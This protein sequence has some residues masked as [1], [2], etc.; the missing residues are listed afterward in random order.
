MAQSSVDGEMQYPVPAARSNTPDSGQN[1]EHEPKPEPAVPVLAEPRPVT[2]SMTP[3]N[4]V[5]ESSL[6]QGRLSAQSPRPIHGHSG[7]MGTPSNKMLYMYHNGSGQRSD[8][9][10]EPGLPSFVNSE[11]IGLGAHYPQSSAGR[12]SLLVSP[13][14][15]QDIRAD[16]PDFFYSQRLNRG[17]TMQAS[18]Q[19]P[20][21]TGEVYG[22]SG[23]SNSPGYFGYSNATYQQVIGGQNVPQVLYFVD[24]N[25]AAASSGHQHI[26]QRQL[27]SPSNNITTALGNSIIQRNTGSPQPQL[28]YMLQEANS[29]VIP[30]QRTPSSGDQFYV[31]MRPPSPSMFAQHSASPILVPRQNTPVNGGDPLLSLAPAAAQ[32]L[33]A[34]LANARARL[35]GAEDVK[36]S[37]NPREQAMTLNKAEVE[38]FL[39][40][41]KTGISS[42]TDRKS[43]SVRKSLG[44]S[45]G[46]PDSRE[47]LF[48]CHWEGC[49][50]GYKRREH[51]NRHIR[52]HTGE[53]PYV[54][55]VSDC[56]K[57]F[58]RSDNL[59]NHY[60]VHQL[61]NEV[62]PEL[63]VKQL[64]QLVAIM[65]SHTHQKLALAAQHHHPYASAGM[66]NAA[67]AV[68]A[69]QLAPLTS[70]NRQ[71]SSS[72]Q[73]AGLSIYSN[74]Y[75]ANQAGSMRYH[76]FDNNSK[77]QQALPLP[78][79]YFAN[80]YL[81]N[82]PPAFRGG[83]P[84]L[85]M[86]KLGVNEKDA[87][88]STPPA[89]LPPRTEVSVSEAEKNSSLSGTSNEA[90]NTASATATS[91]PLAKSLEDRVSHHF[92]TPV[93]SPILA[94]ASLSKHDQLVATTKESTS[95]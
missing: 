2:P 56:R 50:K 42:N 3:S 16:S 66:I 8:I 1:N 35:S 63:T 32:G 9:H 17:A 57:A 24:N 7:L 11:P 25:G 93:A 47:K 39:E 18:I 13:Q 15:S 21:Q 68:A 64:S 41:K 36:F 71:N 90:S 43:A 4:G 27:L 61:R 65:P 34:L 67:A 51:L 85:S 83:S 75:L 52:S 23:V 70:S 54:C 10:N 19:S 95:L 38:R 82:S 92:P 26:D 73:L 86:P 88:A 55:R 12:H 6:L 81:Y 94:N 69:Q 53:R 84:L 77:L 58:T 37:G 44:K 74:D 14:Y 87:L 31:D 60:R 45:G 62:D 89:S 40:D 28:S 72:P 46:G 79:D 5:V 33:C 49:E 20:P 29:F 78:G 30:K 59:I 91:A 22:P 48:K 76:Y 80:Q